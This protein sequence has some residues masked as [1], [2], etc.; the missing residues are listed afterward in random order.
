MWL[1]D[2]QF[3][4]L[5]LQILPHVRCQPPKQSFSSHRWQCSEAKDLRLHYAT[6]KRDWAAG[7]LSFG[8]GFQTE[9]DQ[10]S[11]GFH[12]FSTKV[13]FGLCHLEACSPESVIFFDKSSPTI[14]QCV[15]NGPFISQL[16]GL[17]YKDLRKKVKALTSIC[18][19]LVFS[20]ATL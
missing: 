3:H 12:G 11:L 9:K 17:S 14:C 19:R 6:G 8:F 7:L 13:R 20:C 10:G 4:L 1:G 16:R 2:V 5:R 15:Q 18:W